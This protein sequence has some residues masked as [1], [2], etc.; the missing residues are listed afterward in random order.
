MY[1][2]TG[3]HL[4]AESLGAT[5][6]QPDAFMATRG[7]ALSG[8]LSPE[9]PG[10]DRIRLGPQAGPTVL[11]CSLCGEV[12]RFAGVLGVHPCHSPLELL[13]VGVLPVAPDLADRST[14]FV[15]VGYFDEEYQP[16]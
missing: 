2:F 8:R 10:R 4:L 5:L 16:Y 15:G 9:D 6:A 1:R 13:K 12:G 11:G 3:C 14:V 7:P